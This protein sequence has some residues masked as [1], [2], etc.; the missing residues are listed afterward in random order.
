M[1][2]INLLSR[3]LK[4]DGESIFSEDWNNLII[5]DACRCDT[6][7]KVIKEYVKGSAFKKYKI[8]CK[9]SLGSHTRE[10]LEKNFV[11]SRYN[12]II[13]ITANPFVD[14]ILKDKV[15]NIISVWDIGWD[16]KYNTVMPETIVYY[17]LKS[18]MKYPNKRFIIH[19]VQP[20]YPYVAD[21]LKFQDE[22]ENILRLKL[23]AKSND[24][25]YRVLKPKSNIIYKVFK[26][27]TKGK[28]YD[29]KFYLELDIQKHIKA[30]ENNLRFVLPY[31]LSVANILPGKNVITSDHGEAFGERIHPLIPIKVYGHFPNIYIPE[32]VLVPWMIVVNK[33]SSKEAR[34]IIKKEIIRLKLRK[35]KNEKIGY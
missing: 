34:R 13:Y 4:N 7:I 24:K 21:H 19:F 12:D 32:L 5:L 31:A 29:A 30:Y 15:Y 22:R 28:I 35:I 9:R 8:R 18:Y 27:L 23:Q 11:K 16:R 2:R 26:A 33:I 20:H 1:I 17:T 10:F 3:F 25:K 14:I 6:F